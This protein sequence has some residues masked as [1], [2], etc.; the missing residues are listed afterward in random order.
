MGVQTGP[1]RLRQQVQSGA[2][3]KNRARIGTKVTLTSPRSG[4][5][6]TCSSSLPGRRSAGGTGPLPTACFHCKQN[7]VSV[8]RE[9]HRERHVLRRSRFERANHTAE[10]ESGREVTHRW[11]LLSGCL[12]LGEEYVVAVP[13]RHLG[14]SRLTIRAHVNQGCRR[15]SIRRSVCLSISVML[16]ARQFPPRSFRAQ[17][18][19][20]MCVGRLTGTDH[21]CRLTAVRCSIRRTRNQDRDGA[22]TCGTCRALT[23]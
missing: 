11:K 9:M 21:L 17:C 23:G 8:R 20:D 10:D 2:Y 6:A 16:S 12:G 3:S 15:R 22:T 5:F 19:W 4:I 14:R 13:L 1:G 18:S 7:E